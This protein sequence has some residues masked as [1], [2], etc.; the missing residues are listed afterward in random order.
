MTKQPQI[1]Y[2]TE[3]P[4]FAFNVTLRIHGDQLN[5]FEISKK[6]GLVASHQHRRVEAKKTK[7]L[8]EDDAWH[9]KPP[10]DESQSLSEH[11]MALWETIKPHVEYLRALKRIHKVDIFC[12]YRS[13]N[14]T[15]GFEVDYRCLE[16]F[17]AL[18]IPFGISIITL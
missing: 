2:P 15:A 12:G 17:I 16:M 8:W 3:E 18:E 13:N 7:G 9:Y 5:F 10:I 14:Q 6:L 4:W 1:I 11:L